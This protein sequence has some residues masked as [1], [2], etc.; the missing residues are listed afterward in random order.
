MKLRLLISVMTGCSFLFSSGAFAK[1]SAKKQSESA[2]SPLSDADYNLVQGGASCWL[3]QGKDHYFYDDGTG[4]VKIN[5]KVYA[6]KPT[7]AG[8][9]FTGDAKIATFEGDGGKLKVTVTKSGK[10][11]DLTTTFEGKTLKL[12]NLSKDC[13]D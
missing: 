5:H 1:S 4:L 3:A 6:L 9:I 12:K 10:K 7:T 13:G 2:I 8:G 11:H